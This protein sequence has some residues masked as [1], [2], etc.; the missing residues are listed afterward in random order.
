MPDHL[1]PAVRIL[2]MDSQLEFQGQSIR[3]AQRQFFLGDLLHADRPPGKYQYREAGLKAES[4]TV[5]LFQY[6]GKIIASATL[7]DVERFATPQ[8]G[9]Y[10]G[11]LYF[12]AGS[13]RVFDPVGSDAVVA[14]WPKFKRFSHVKQKLAV[15]GLAEFESKLTG[16]ERS[17]LSSIP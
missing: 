11:A 9:V 5:V 12:D 7:I 8:E 16:V 13:I 2:P 6:E 1:P 3:E 4:G 17:R 14:V 10:R 15:E